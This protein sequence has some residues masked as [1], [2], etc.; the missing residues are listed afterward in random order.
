VALGGVV[1]AQ[2]VA[3]LADHHVARV[4]PH[5]DREIQSFREPQLVGVAAELVAQAQRRVAG[6]LRVVFVGYGRSEERH[7]AVAGVLVD[8][9][10]E[11]VYALGQDFEE[12]VQDGVPAF[13]ID[14]L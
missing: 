3:D 2:V 7:D 14:L 5:P 9:A 6:A 10:L 4:E 8:R 13:G 1:H 11:P 12:A